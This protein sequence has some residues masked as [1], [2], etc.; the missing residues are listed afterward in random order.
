ML[1]I[2]SHHAD[3]M[4]SVKA[5]RKVR[6]DYGPVGRKVYCQDF[7]R[8]TSQENVYGNYLIGSERGREQRSDL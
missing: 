5:C 1:G 8:V 6:S 7:E 2:V 4:H 3:G